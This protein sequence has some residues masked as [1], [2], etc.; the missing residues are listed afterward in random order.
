LQ[1]FLRVANSGS[2]SE[3]AQ[4]LF[5]T[6]PAVSKR[7]AAL[8]QQL[9][10]RLFDRLGRQLLLTEAGQL[11]LHRA[12]N[13]VRDIQDCRREI[14]N[15]SGQVG[16]PLKFA[17]S[18]HIGLH[19]LPPVLRYFNSHY[20]QVK[21]NLNFMDSEQA[22]RHVENANMELAIITLP[23]Q[24]PAK[25]HAQ[26]L[27]ND[28]LQLVVGKSHPLAQSVPGG[29]SL[30]QISAYPGIL[31]LAGT[32]T[33]AL[34]EA[35]FVSSQLPLTTHMDTNFL[36][37]IKMLV[38]VGLGWSVLPRTLLDQ[39]LIT[40][41][42]PELILKRPLGVVWQQDRTLSNAANAMLQFLSQAA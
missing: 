13:I 14:S 40:P 24:I 37:T 17:T 30:E 33:R 39:D 9:Q 19:R 18:H 35:V 2:F 4:S 27:W 5:L 3:A 8:E 26:I 36:E 32:T 21:L 23:I 29:Y 28:E 6:Q 20:P 16:G 10:T 25:L 11:L 31:P 42:T 1:T 7:I 22:C 38:S 12:E 34:I 41:D 15:L